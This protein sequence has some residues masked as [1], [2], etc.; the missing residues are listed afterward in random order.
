MD[1][2]GSTCRKPNPS[3]PFTA[4]DLARQIQF[5]MQLIFKNN[6]AILLLFTAVLVFLPSFAGAAGLSDAVYKYNDIL[7]RILDEMLPSCDRLINVGRVIGGVGAFLYI[8]VRVWKHLARAEAIDFFPLLRPFALGMAIVMFPF[9]IKIMN[10]VLE[11]IVEG[12]REMSSD[13]L[14]AIYINIDEQEKALKQDAPV[15]VDQA[16]ADMGKYEQPD[17]S[18]ED[19]V[20]SGLRNAFSWFNIKSFVKVFVLEIV[21]TLYTAVGLCINTIRTFYLIILAII[22]PLVFSLSIFDGFQNSL[23]NWFARYINVFLWLPI[24][25][26]VGGI[27]SKILVN[28]STM[29]QGFF[30]STVYI[31]FMII[32][33]VCYTTVPNVA[34]FI[35]QAG[36]RDTLLHKINNMTQAG[37]KA[38]MAVIGKL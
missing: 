34:G 14:T 1:N 36:G 22:G 9:V 18:T 38:A 24:C 11:P 4:T 2:A 15:S 20:F 33:I 12:T 30:S 25:N 6:R 8:S 13:A 37:G 7:K 21:Q 23:S 35:V 16:P 10:G 5:P 17:G 32:S 28:L 26:I 19:G 29:D 31:I 27:S 3:G